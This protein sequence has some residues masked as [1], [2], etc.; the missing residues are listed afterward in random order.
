MTGTDLPGCNASRGDLGQSATTST[1][2]SVADRH[3][4][5]RKPNVSGV[6]LTDVNHPRNALVA[7]VVTVTGAL[8]LGCGWLLLQDD[9]VNGTA[10]PTP[11]TTTVAEATT[12]TTPSPPPAEVELQGDGLGRVPF[13]TPF[14]EAMA[15]LV[16]E[17]G[18]PLEDS[19]EVPIEETCAGP[20]DFTRA[21][22][23]SSAET[24]RF[25]R[26]QDLKLLF[27]G[28]TGQPTLQ[29]WYASGDDLATS[30]GLRITDPVSRWEERYS[31]AF[32]TRFFQG[33]DGGEGAWVE[34]V[35]L[36]LPD[37][38]ITGYTE[39]AEPP[40]YIDSIFAGTDCSGGDY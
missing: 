33:N 24:A 5:A 22:V 32:T 21:P 38:H 23:C 4:I 6:P 10:A 20:C 16:A 19:G 15:V 34:A 14:D 12:T 30:A 17:L 31:G 40:G 35:N 27:Y 37:G 1:P 39:S 13:G 7:L 18:E 36:E 11:T 28:P 8:L 9:R 2:D 25:V 3:T 29:G 26:W